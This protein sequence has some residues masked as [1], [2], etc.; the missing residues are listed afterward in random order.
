MLILVRPYAWREAAPATDSALL[1]ADLL[2]V[3]A[4]S[5]NP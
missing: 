5:L 4:G 2:L 3:S 1:R